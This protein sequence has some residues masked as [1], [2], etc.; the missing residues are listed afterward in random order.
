MEVTEEIHDPGLGRAVES[1]PGRGLSFVFSTI[2]IFGSGP[3]FLN[4]SIQ[5]IGI[6]VFTH[7]LRY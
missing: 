5:R 2:G 4:G 6:T 7:D 1:F 3:D